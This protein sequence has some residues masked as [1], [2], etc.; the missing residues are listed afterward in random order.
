MKKRFSPDPIFYA[1]EQKIAKIQA[2]QEELERIYDCAYRGLKGDALAIASGFLPVDFN[3]LCQ[4]DHK[5]QEAVLY[6]R[7]R[8]EADISGALMQNALGGDTKAQTTV[9]THLHN[10]QPARA[11][12]D[13]SNEIRIVVENADPRNKKVANET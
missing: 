5:A 8:N 13:T 4:F 10:W 2:T 11:D 9:L 12:T 7:A 1:V 6:A 3:R